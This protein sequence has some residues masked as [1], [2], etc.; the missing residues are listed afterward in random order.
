[1]NTFKSTKFAFG[2]ILFFITVLGYG[3][4]IERSIY[5]IANT[6]ASDDQKIL[7]QITRDAQK[8]NAPTI[9]ILG[10]AVNEDGYNEINTENAIKKQL[11][12]IS[13]FED[14]AIFIP[15][16]NEWAIKGHN[17]VQALEEYIQK[18]SKA[19]FYP[20]DSE[21]IKYR[22]LGDNVVLVTIDSQ[23]F[24]E[25]WN[26]HIYLNDASEIQN[27]T[28][29]FLEF[30]DLIKKAAGKIKIVAIHHPIET[31][32]KQGLLAN[33]G[34]TS[35]Q[36]FQSKPYKKLR[37]RLKTIARETDHVIFV[38]GHDQN[39]Q[40]LNKGVPQII[41]GAAGLIKN[42]KKVGEGSF[43]AAKNGYARL[44][45]YTDSEVVVHFFDVENGVGKSLFTT[46]IFNGNKEN[47]VAQYNIKSV[48][49]NTKAAPIYTQEAT[50][51]SGFYKALWGNHYREFYSRAVNAQ[52][53]LLDTLMGGLTPLKRGGGQQSKSLR[54]EAKSGKQFVMRALKKSTIKFLQANA[55]QDTYI[56][57]ALD[58]SIIDKFLADFYTTSH[59]YTPFVIGDLSDA[60]DVF[61]T[62]PKLFYIPK[63][64]VLGEFNA[65]F[66][67]ELYMIEEHVGATQLEAKNFGNPKKILSTAEVFEEIHKTGKSSVDEPSY[68]RARLF[69][70]LLGDW[71]RHEDQWRWA[72]FEK[73]DGS[74]ICKPIPRD[75]DQAFSK[76]DGA[77][78][79]FLTRAIPGLRKMQSYGDDLRSVKWFASSPYHL[80]LTFI[81]N[82]GWEVWEK[83][84]KYIQDNMTDQAIE[85]AF[86]AI[87]D[88]IKGETI[89][90]IKL[91]FKAR[92]SNLIRIAKVY[93]TYLNK[94]EVVVG[95]QKKDEFRITRFPDGKTSIEV[96]RKDLDILNRTF[97]HDITKEIWIYGLDGKDTFTVDGKGDQL[98]P[99]KIIGGKKNDTY[100]FKNT[101]KV[102]LYD[103]KKKENTIVNKRS[104]K[105][106]VDDYDINN[107]D[108]H[109]VKHSFDQILPIVAVNPDD[110]LRV[111]IL[112]NHTFFGFQRNPFTQKHT[113]SASYY[114]GTSGYDLS[115]KGEFSN[116]FHKWNFAMEGLYTSPNFASNFFGFGN[117]TQYDKDQVDLDF[118]R[119]R[120]RKWNAVISLI[121]RGRNGG[122]FHIKP[123]IESLDV[124]NTQE[125]FIGD[126]PNTSSVFEKQTYGGMELAYEFKNKDNL[127]FP[128]LG[129]DFSLVAGYKANIDNTT[130]DNSFVYFQPEIAID[131]KLTKTGS[132]V[133]ASKL[134]GE[135]IIGDDFEFYHAAQIGGVNG[136]RGFRN[137]RFTG[138]QAFFQN[139]DLR[140]PIGGLK[141]SVIPIRLGF[142]ASFDY[143]RVWAEDDSSG[144]W[145]NS[146]GGSIWVSGVEALTANLGYFDS[147]D[148]GRFV[149]TLGFA[150]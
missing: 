53:V 148:G 113:I 139:T 127:A 74:E 20:D 82:S 50:D 3:Q 48:F 87:P 24:L 138:K 107:Y 128:T 40:Y 30:E 13:T 69:D 9:L 120:I 2:I 126:L 95:T 4:E 106:L 25:D 61:H 45:I 110:G 122:S 12:A 116:I 8:M 71:D 103:Y 84:A 38:S 41:S 96:Q 101:K 132:L 83:Q 93:Y 28:L 44:D 115:Y 129:L 15:G 90:D 141:T 89:S 39:L 149:F 33:T 11:R 67:D 5:F 34:G 119:V 76:Y 104:K 123:L 111:G 99:I 121:Y 49:P 70:M 135:L 143:G 142:T 51:K 88:E 137:E 58:G 114:T 108:H 19:K 22:K 62:N 1:M 26:N 105:W 100:D 97:S 57:N 16:N 29:F 60:I 42:V 131:H 145:H 6:G 63:Q 133:L 59:P 85:M 79:A 46:S 130:A 150:F 18:N 21:P 92:R 10:N 43:A 94:F 14:N 55:F 35:I 112:S 32:T 68:I 72:V 80:D 140:I 109:K 65:D 124:E 37:K 47:N 27:R 7:D 147:T 91:K 64:E 117:E 118:N 17:G 98:I 31:N 77:L 52:V 75:R 125:R 56:G 54:L 86:K 36:N 136:L 146:T 144:R 134:A 23:W 78:I 81:N 66:G 102:K 73:E